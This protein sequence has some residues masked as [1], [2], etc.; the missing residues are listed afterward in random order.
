MMLR[1]DIDPFAAAAW[2]GYVFVTI[3]PFEVSVKSRMY[4]VRS[5]T[6]WGI[7]W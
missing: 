2:A 6:L 1:P 7:G 4:R 3:H 5:L